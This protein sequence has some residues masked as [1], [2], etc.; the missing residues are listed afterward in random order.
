MQN[1]PPA[2]DPACIPPDAARPDNPLW[3]ALFDTALDCIIS[4]DHTGR[5][6]DLNR[7]AEDTFGWPRKIAIGRELAELIIPKRLRAAHHAGLQRYLESGV[8]PVLGSRIEVPALHADGHEFPVELAI[9]RLP[10]AG[11]PVFVAYLRDIGARLRLERLR[12]LRAEAMQAIACADSIDASADGVLQAFCSLMDWELGFVWQRD[13]D[14][15]RCTNTY[16]ATPGAKPNFVAATHS[17]QL[18]SGKGLPGTAWASGAPVWRRDVSV[19]DNFPRAAMALLDGVRA[20]VACPVT[21]DR[22]VI[23]A[24]EFYSQNIREPDADLVETLAIVSAQLGQAWQRQRTEIALRDAH[25][26]KDEFLAMLAHELRNPL[27]PIS[28]ALRIL[29]MP[30]ASESMHEDARQIIGRQVEHLVR[31]VDDLLDVSR[32]IGGKVTLRPELTDL[33]RVV[34]RAIEVALPTLKA[35]NHDFVAHLPSSPVMLDVDEVRITQAIGN[36]LTNA[37]R[38]TP[39]GGSVVLEAQ[40]GP[41][42]VEVGVRDTGI[43]IDASMVDKVFDLFVQAD[44]DDASTH[45]GLGIGLTLARQL[46]RLHGGDITVSSAG[47]GQGSLFLLT[48]PRSDRPAA[49][50]DPEGEATAIAPI[51]VLVVDD[52]Q[53]AA[54]SMALLL[55]LSN[56]NVRTCNDG[57]SA[58][59]AAA[60]RRPR[61]ILLDLG[62]PGMDGF[63]VARRLRAE[64]GAPLVIV[65]LSGWGQQSDRE[66]TAEAGFDRHLVKPVAAG[67]LER[68]LED[69]AAG[70]FT[71]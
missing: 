22:E 25:Q 16:E 23:G 57:A 20:G 31:L 3:R 52:N 33:E 11:P 66:R 46:V 55:R 60:E 34:S 35:R 2:R 5:V 38:Y 17:I 14:I 69:V 28:T 6:L 54:W 58:L 10:T 29:D 42:T 44:H 48:L 15:L 47:R 39:P 56:H 7:A 9:S 70:R 24:I 71:R 65:A 51:D 59:A 63:E 45:G 27:A 13:A 8:G 41:R 18:P 68:L 43:G 62:M 61:L 36:L 32:F 53:D 1:D 21:L 64:P 4:M 50:T 40:A 26:R 19:A 49:Q 30:E 37:A 12:T 67:E